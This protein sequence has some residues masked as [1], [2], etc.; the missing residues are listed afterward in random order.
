MIETLS[1]KLVDNTD[2]KFDHDTV[3]YNIH[4]PPSKYVHIMFMHGT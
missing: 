1:L 4:E 3:S 2:F